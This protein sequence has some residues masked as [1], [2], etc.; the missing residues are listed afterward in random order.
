V[1]WNAK[2]QTAVLKFATISLKEG[3]NTITFNFGTKN[4][5]LSALY[6]EGAEGLIFGAKE[7]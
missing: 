7:N 5:N 2:T 6:L 1:G 4:H 3:V